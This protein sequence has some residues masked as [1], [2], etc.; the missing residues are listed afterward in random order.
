MERKNIAKKEKAGCNWEQ[1]KRTEI[2]KQD[3]KEMER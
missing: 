2:K 1:K 3:R